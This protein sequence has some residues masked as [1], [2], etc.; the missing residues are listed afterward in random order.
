[1]NMA[2]NYS[3]GM[4]ELKGLWNILVKG[5]IRMGIELKQDSQTLIII[6]LDHVYI[7]VFVADKCHDHL[8][9]MGQE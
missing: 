3:L 5:L 2:I 9:F 1:M 4:L 8:N 6:V 7:G